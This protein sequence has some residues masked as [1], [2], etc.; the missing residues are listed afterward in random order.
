LK[1]IVDERRL[2]VAL[3]IDGGIKADTAPSAVA[4]GASMLVSGTG[5]FNECEPPGEAIARLRRAI[6]GE[7]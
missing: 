4:A 1:A 7:R 5:V 6:S 2:D 3:E